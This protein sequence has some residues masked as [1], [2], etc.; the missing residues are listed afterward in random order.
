MESASLQYSIKLSHLKDNDT[1][2]YYQFTPFFKAMNTFFGLQ[3]IPDRSHGFNNF[4]LS[5]WNHL[6]V[7]LSG[8]HAW[9]RLN[10]GV[11]N[12]TNFTGSLPYDLDWDLPLH[13]GGALPHLLN[14]I[15]GPNVAGKC[16]NLLWTKTYCTNVM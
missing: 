16:V 8:N 10:D 11:T 5:A 15:P 9:L 6:E 2:C 13:V 4:Q 3:Y 14:D 1:F 12:T 7:G